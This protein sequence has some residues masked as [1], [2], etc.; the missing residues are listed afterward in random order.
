MFLETH[1]SLSPPPRPSSITRKVR[2][3]TLE[4]QSGLAWLGVVRCGVV[5]CGGVWCLAHTHLA[6]DNS[7]NHAM[8]QICDTVE[9][10]K[11]RKE[12]R[13][14]DECFTVSWIN[15]KMNEMSLS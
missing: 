13:R 15:N 11:R 5:W 9:K 10:S 7:Q 2:E 3:G 8:P 6:A 14:L 4:G 12:H 1:P